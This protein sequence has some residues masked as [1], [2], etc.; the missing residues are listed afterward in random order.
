MDR[1]AVFALK[2]QPERLVL[3]L[4]D[5]KIAAA[6]TVVVA[7]LLDAARF[8]IASVLNPVLELNGQRFALATEQMA[9]IP[10]KALGTQAG[11]CLAHEYPIANAINRL[12]FGV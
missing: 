7:P 10:V 8:P 1:L 11:S 9:A 3:V 6:G 4:S 12:F 5:P 2:S